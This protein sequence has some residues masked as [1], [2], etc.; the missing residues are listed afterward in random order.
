M[1][2]MYEGGGKSSNTLVNGLLKVNSYEILSRRVTFM[3]LQVSNLVFA[4]E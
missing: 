4:Y 1:R 2:G 3:D